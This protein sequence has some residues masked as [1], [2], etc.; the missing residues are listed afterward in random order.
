MAITQRPAQTPLSPE[1]NKQLKEATDDL[2]KYLR[3]FE[4]NNIDD[5][6]SQISRDEP[7]RSP[8]QKVANGSAGPSSAPLANAAA[9]PSVAGAGAATNETIASAEEELNKKKELDDPN[10]NDSTARPIRVKKFPGSFEANFSGISSPTNYMHLIMNESGKSSNFSARGTDIVAVFA[11]LMPSVELSKCVPYLRINFIQNVSKATNGQMPFLTLESFLG[12][13]RGSANESTTPGYNAG[14]AGVYTPVIP[15]QSNVG[16][17]Q[18]GMELFLAPQTLVN[19]SINQSSAYRANRGINVLD[20]MQPLMSLESVNIDV[21]AVSQNLMQTQQKID[22]SIVLH[23]RSRLAEISPL[24]SPTVFPTISVEIEWGWSHPDTNAMSPNV[25][26]RFLNA[27]RTRQV[28]SI[29]TSSISN[30]DS[31]S[32][33]VKVQLI[34]FGDQV[35]RAAAVTTGTAVEGTNNRYV[36]YDLVKA[37]LNQIVRVSESNKANKNDKTT[38]NLQIVGP[39]QVRIEN[40]GWPTSDKWVK[41][42]DYKAFSDA[43]SEVTKDANKAQE[44]VEKYR[45]ILTSVAQSDDDKP[46]ASNLSAELAKSLSNEIARM[47]YD[48]SGYVNPTNAEKRDAKG[49]YLV[50]LVNENLSEAGVG[51]FSALGD[52]IFRLYTFPLAAAKIFDEIRI[53]TYDCNDNAGYMG[54]V[55]IGCIPIPNNEIIGL[56]QGSIIKPR[57]TVKSS[58]QQL[59]RNVNNKSALA[60]GFRE[61]YNSAVRMQKEV[62]QA[63][64]DNDAEEIAA[65]QAEVREKI[66]ELFDNQLAEI[67]ANRRSVFPSLPNEASF[68]PPRIKIE[69]IVVPLEGGG[70]GLHVFIFDEANSGYRHVNL[71]TSML[72]TTSGQVALMST[73]GV[74]DTDRIKIQRIA[75]PKGKGRILYN[76]TIDRNTAKSIL[77]YTYPTLRIGTAGSV[78]TN[79]TYSSSTTGEIANINIL[80]GY[81]SQVNPAADESGPPI[82]AD[83][84]VLPVSVNIT[85]LGMPV[86]NRGQVY[87]IDF[88]TGTTVDNVYVVMS[89]KHTIKAGLFTTSVTF[90]PLNSGTVRSVASALQTEPISKY[91]N[92]TPPPAAPRRPPGVSSEVQGY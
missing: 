60:Y 84:F 16:N 82:N 64:T 38:T 85:M 24:V 1:S 48:Q 13:A 88:G 91:L 30:R 44:A 67:Y 8:E 53:V 25:Y 75:D 69:E 46:V 32:L 63:E 23:D 17:Y 14:V 80:N 56:T 9:P 37:K 90:N 21:S 22:L 5:L 15:P 26:A 76:A 40:P 55:N 54:G 29:Y 83:L 35:T 10:I 78:I 36:P 31:T 62:A 89:V 51:N 68:T 3:M 86:I 61:T 81:K 33:N 73:T 41:Y 12:A 70:Q 79:A 74:P 52:L 47:T 27:L 77:T 4:F 39:D 58:L 66:Q 65:N 45:K 34:S 42:D 18:T 2:F 49:D 7:R 87:Y 28:Y 43:V 19:P 20:P 71:I 72:S 57:M 11:N 59:I 92:A 6:I 50:N